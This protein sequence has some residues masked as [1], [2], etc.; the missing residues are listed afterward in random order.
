MN[1][2]TPNWYTIPEFA[3]VAPIFVYHKEQEDN[4]QP[5]K[6]PVNVHVLARSHYRFKRDQ[7][8]VIL[9]ISADDYYKLYIN[10]RFVLQGPASA[11][12]EAYYYNQVEITPYLSEGDNVLSLHLYYQ[13]LINRVWNSGDGRFGVAA[14]VEDQTGNSQELSWKY[15]RSNAFKGETTGYDTQFL[16][17]FDSR[18]WD[19]DWN[20]PDYDDSLW[21]PMVPAL[22]ADYKLSCQPVKPLAVY[23]EEPKNIIKKRE[24]WFLDLGREVTGALKITAS[25]PEGGQIRILC[26]EELNEDGTVRYEMRCNCRYEETWTLREGICT[27]D[28]YDYKGFRY[29]MLV[30]DEGVEIQKVTAILRH[31]PLEDSSCQLESSSEALDKIFEIC[32]NGVRLGTQE[33]YL[34]CPTREKGQYLGDSVVTARSQVWLSGTVEMLRKCIDQFARTKEI[35]PGLMGVAPGSFMQEI[36]DFSLLWSQL[37][38]LD[39]Q[40]TGDKEFLRQY[41]PVAK[42]ILEHF[43]RYAREDG[44]LEQVGDK[45]NLVDWPE[46]LRDGYDFAL[47]RPVVAPGCHNVINALYAG[48]AK[49]LNWIE[50]ILGQ[51]ETVDWK[52]LKDSFVKAFYRPQFRL[53]ADSETSNHSSLH[54][55]I[56]PLFFKMVPEDGVDSICNYMIEKG[57]CCGVLISWFYLKGLAGAGRFEEVYQTIVNKSEHGWIQMLKEGATSCWEAWGK[58]QKWNTSFCHP[59]ASAPISVFIE[60]VAGFIPDPEEKKGFRFEPHLPEELKELSLTIPFRGNSFTIQKKDGRIFLE[61]NPR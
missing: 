6:V 51:E 41:Y 38:V 48:A 54:S 18:L 8:K 59:W 2:F 19:E 40:F 35:C 20:Q 37:L 12:P 55:N 28:P 17:N 49:T 42:G 11:Y 10:G 26:G 13:G 1:Q 53:F 22:W 4:P 44:L 52:K 50:K 43:S 45:W 57:L 24:G 23:E 33:A 60:D 9:R 29:A 21:E 27:L 47:S 25:G 30:P 46:N 34:D 61:E 16:E 15:K 32:K 31:Y 58:D 5:P 56:Y 39:Y 7:G 14:A 3:Q 36:G